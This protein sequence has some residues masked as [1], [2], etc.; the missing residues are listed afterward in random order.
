MQVMWKINKISNDNF[1]QNYKNI[2]A[3]DYEVNRMLNENCYN[4]NLIELKFENQLNIKLLNNF[5]I[6]IFKLE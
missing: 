6:F 5:N 1:F 2:K 4:N 3:V